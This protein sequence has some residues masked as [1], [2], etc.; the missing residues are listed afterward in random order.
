MNKVLI[1][2]H[3]TCI[4][5]CMNYRDKYRYTVNTER[6]S[7]LLSGRRREFCYKVDISESYLAHILTGG[8]I[9]ALDIM[10]ATV[11]YLK[12]RGENISFGELFPSIDEAS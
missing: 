3:V 12:D 9:P 7:E 2:M 8:K 10:L 11:D 6:L 4:I 5:V 1:L